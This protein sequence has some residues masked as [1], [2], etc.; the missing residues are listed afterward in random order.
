[1]QPSVSIVAR[2]LTRTLRLAMRLAIM[3]NDKAT[4]TGRPLKQVEF[5]LWA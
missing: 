3:V 5:V 4:Q 1:M 2:F